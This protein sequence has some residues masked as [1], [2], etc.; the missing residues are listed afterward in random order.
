MLPADASTSRYFTALDR[1]LPE[2]AEIVDLVVETVDARGRSTP[3]DGGERAADGHAPSSVGEGGA[4][5][6]QAVR[7]RLQAAT[8]RLRGA[9]NATAFVSA[10]GLGESVLIWRGGVPIASRTRLLATQYGPQQMLSLRSTVAYLNNHGLDAASDDA[11]APAAS[12]GGEW[13]PGGVGTDESIPQPSSGGRAFSYAARDVYLEQDALMVPYTARSVGLVLAAVVATVF[14][15]T[16]LPGFAWAMALCTV[17][18]CV[19]MLGWMHLTATPLNALS[20]I[21]L[22]L[23]IGLSI[24]YCTHL[25]H[26]FWN[27]ADDAADGARKRVVD[28]VLVGAGTASGGASGDASGGASGD[29]SGGASGGADDFARSPGERARAAFISRARPVAAGAASTF[30][31]TSLL[32]LGRTLIMQTFFVMFSGIALVGAYHALVILPVCLSLLPHHPARERRSIAWTPA[33]DR[34]ISRRDRRREPRL[35]AQEEASSSAACDDFL[36]TLGTPPTHQ[37]AAAVADAVDE[38]TDAAV[39]VAVAG[40]AADGLASRERAVKTAACA[41]RHGRT[42]ATALGVRGG[43]VEAYPHRVQGGGIEEYGLASH[44]AGTVAP[45][46]HD[47]SK[48]FGLEDE[49]EDPFDACERAL[50]ERAAR[51]SA[52]EPLYYL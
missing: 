18:S 15:L 1:T 26:A 17:S 51:G 21:P 41:A 34:A 33:R 24:D 40:K 29:A 12:K 25:A 7:E 14:S 27:A 48:G 44:R 39:Q 32:A 23:S 47:L 4:R 3:R 49:E 46:K 43:S 22:L 42:A 50:V 6:L 2:R 28:E 37:A 52:D 38:A 16:L 8:R 45:K 35:C 31:A 9:M 11:D 20:L 5:E 13:D 19:H 10:D 36:P 30:V